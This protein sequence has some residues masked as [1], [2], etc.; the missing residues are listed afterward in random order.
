MLLTDSRADTSQLS[1][2]Y[3]R[4]ERLVMYVVSKYISNHSVAEECVNEVFLKLMPILHRIDD[5]GSKKTRSLICT[6]SRNVAINT[7]KKEHSELFERELPDYGIASEQ[8]VFAKVYV[9]EALEAIDR[10]PDEYRDVLE[11]KVYH[12]LS[13]K[14]M[15]LICN[16]TPSAVR[17]RLSRARKALLQLLDE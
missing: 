2:L 15:S 14:E 9:K 5:V 1:L 13:D 4:Y 8:D 6:V 16:M 17:K 7:S 10:L 3:E 11:L 12:G